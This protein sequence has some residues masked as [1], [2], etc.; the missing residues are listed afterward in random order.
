[1]QRGD[2]LYRIALRFGTTIDALVAANKLSNRNL[3]YVGQ[4]LSIPNRS[5]ASASGA[6]TDA[7]T[8]ATPIATPGP[9]A[10]ASAQAV[11]VATLPPY[12]TPTIKE[13]EAIFQPFEHGF[14]I[15]LSDSKR[16]WVAVCC[17]ST[18]PQG[19]RWLSF[20]DAF[21]QGLPE[22]DP[23]LTPPEGLFQPVRGLGLVWRSLSDPFTNQGLRDELGWANA[24]EQN[25]VARVEYLVGG[26]F[27]PDGNFIGRPGTWTINTPAT[28]GQPA[29][30]YHFHEA[31][32]A[33]S[34]LAQY[35][36][37]AAATIRSH[38]I[39]PGRR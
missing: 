22:S 13:V 30:R 10:A 11:Q 33:W 20:D 36:T 19:G 23:A 9:A 18:T 28:P 29:Q 1:V 26:F 24:P 27:D 3:I 35:T 16:I 34:L 17:T 25:Y 38:A 14:M 2:N 7:A 21:S 39:H 5:G 6:N 31:G 12:P 32:P 15:R 37:G 4:Q 8:A